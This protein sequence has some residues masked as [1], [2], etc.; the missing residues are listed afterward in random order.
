MGTAFP[1]GSSPPRALP[2][3]PPRVAEGVKGARRKSCGR[4]LLDPARPPSSPRTPSAAVRGARL[5]REPHGEAL[6]LFL[7]SRAPFDFPPDALAWPFSPFEPV[8][9]GTGLAT[10][11]KRET[12]FNNGSLG[13]RND[14]ERSEMR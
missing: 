11:E 9:S 5:R 12:T 8:L 4:G 3:V 1:R 10:V 7:A 13:S 6:L 2:T 14:E